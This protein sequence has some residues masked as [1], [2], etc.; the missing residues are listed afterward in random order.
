MAA[1]SNAFTH[2][3]GPC[4]YQPV[5]NSRSKASHR[6]KSVLNQATKTAQNSTELREE[7]NV[8]LK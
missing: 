4:D 2:L 8:C 3:Q 1:V 7:E 6:N 5:A